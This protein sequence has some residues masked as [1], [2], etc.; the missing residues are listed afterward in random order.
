MTFKVAEAGSP[1]QYQAD[2]GDHKAGDVVESSGGHMWYSLEDGVDEPQSYGFAS[3]LGSPFGEGAVTN[4]DD[5]AYSQTTYEMD[6]ELTEEQFTT[7]TNFSISPKEYGFNSD[8][9]NVLSNSCVDFVFK[10]LHILGYNPTDYHGDLLPTEN[11]DDVNRLLYNYGA[12]IVLHDL[13]RHGD[14]YQ[15][16]DGQQSRWL[17]AD[18][19][20]AAPDIPSPINVEINTSPQPQQRVEGESKAQQDV[21]NGFIKNTATDNVFA[22]GN[23]L[24][25][26]DFASTQM[27]G[28]ASGGVRPGEVQ[29]D[30]NPR[31]NAHLSS[32][33]AAPDAE[34][35][36]F[37]LRNATTLNGL[38]TQA[39]FNTYVDPLL[40]DLTGEGVRM[41][42]LSDAV[43]F[44][45]DHSGT[46][47]RSG[48]A[49]PSTGMLVVDDGSG[50]VSNASQMFSEY[51]GGQAGADGAAGERR[52]KDGF[53]AL[54]SEDAD[55]DGVIGPSDPVWSKLRVWVDSS[56][57]AKVDGG[58]LKT[59]DELGISQLT[60]SPTGREPQA[61]D[62][63][64]VVA[65]GTFTANG[66]AREMLAVDFVSE[67]VSNRV[68]SEEGGVRI[69]STT[70]GNDS[71]TITAF[72]S[73]SDTAQTLDAAVL[74]VNNLYGG[75]G[76]DTLTAAP[77]GSWLAGGAGS[78]TYNGGAGDDVFVISASDAPANI[79]GNGGR[80]TAIIVGKEV[81]N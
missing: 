80:D 55:Q 62:G 2:K 4:N 21:S 39:S 11:I 33:Y 34:S 22:S 10:A 29:T 76:D 69:T 35:P 5:R 44:D 71:R 27:A 41:T 77:A 70:G 54:A 1:Y 45:T 49:G 51:Y 38:S 78:N 81:W 48:W 28:M 37:S 72:A 43:L 64:R 16:K 19:V 74:G 30:P 18:D 23:L 36:D 63:N 66:Q 46:L 3:K 68:A 53:A 79:H 59:L 12:D 56:H 13:D 65:S 7:L 58:E 26:S 40:L 52:F 32:F 6:I 20:T 8:E 57:D 9:Y 17:T 31:P 50:Q 24:S 15:A 73:Q 42:D 25:D 14:H 75:S 67:A 47:K 60:V 61:R